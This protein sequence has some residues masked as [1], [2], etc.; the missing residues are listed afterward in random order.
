MNLAKIIVIDGADNSGKAT[1]TALLVERLKREGYTV[2]TMDFPRYT[3]NTFGKLIKE[4]LKGLHGD[5]VQKDPRVASL[6]YAADRFESKEALAELLAQNDV[7]VLDRYVS[8]NMLHQGAKI[9][10][11][12]ER[13]EFLAWL[14]HVEY[15]IFG[16][17]RPDLTVMLAVSPEHSY[18][19]LQRMVQEGLKTA[20]LAEQDREHQKRVAECASWLSSMHKNWNTIQCSKGETLRTKEDIHEELFSIIKPIL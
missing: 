1:Q 2:G 16:I 14:E 9:D 17:P 3:Q 5:F 7:V 18:Q 4:S 12:S 20:D 13:A 6:L 15:D 10:D 19:V 8:A 11:E